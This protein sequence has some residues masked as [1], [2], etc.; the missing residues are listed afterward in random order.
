LTRRSIE[1][2]LFTTISLVF[3]H[4]QSVLGESAAR[5]LVN[6]YVDSYYDEN[7]INPSHLQQVYATRQLPKASPLDSFQ[8]IGSS[9]LC[10]PKI[11]N[12]DESYS[13][14]D[15][16]GDD[17]TKIKIKE[18]G[19]TKKMMHLFKGCMAP[20]L[21]HC[22]GGQTAPRLHS[23]LSQQSTSSPTPTLT[24]PTPS[25][26]TH[27]RTNI[28]TTLFFN[29]NLS[30]ESSSQ[31]VIGKQAPQSHPYLYEILLA[32]W[33]NSK[34]PLFSKHISFYLKLLAK[35]LALR[36]DDKLGGVGQQF[37]AHLDELHIRSFIQLIDVVS[38]SQNTNTS[39]AISTFLFELMHMI[40][41]SDS[42]QLVGHYMNLVHST[43]T[44]L[45]V[46]AK[47]SSS[48]AF[49][50]MN[51]PAPYPQF[52]SRDFRTPKSWNSQILAPPPQWQFTEEEESLSG[53]LVDIL[54]SN[55]FQL[56]QK[57]AKVRV[58]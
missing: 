37:L 6:T 47:L 1:S 8:C 49:I 5:K 18:I 56:M 3:S 22:G 14:I 32:V 39:Q 55:Y 40:Q 43:K 16:V 7:N 12:N 36:V 19:Q 25:P 46:L 58:I 48:S 20:P 38:A 45:A 24:P 11:N 31:F 34:N 13:L 42:K 44:K 57:G 23:P 4:V 51:C 2:Y 21:T 54:L 27:T 9:T 26:S 17:D 35:S 28:K 10:Q 33:L 29:F 30:V 52:R 15:F 50:Q 41:P 53:W